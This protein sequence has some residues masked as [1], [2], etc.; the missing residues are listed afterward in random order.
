MGHAL[1]LLAGN[2]PELQRK[3]FE[4]MRTLFSPELLDRNGV[5]TLASNE[6]RFVPYS[7][8][9][10]SVWPWDNKVIADELRLVGAHGLAHDLEAR[11]V[12]MV[13]TIGHFTE[14]V[15]GNNGETASE[16]TIHHVVDVWDGDPKHGNRKHYSPFYRIAKPAQELQAWTVEAVYAIENGRSVPTQAKDPALRTFERNVLRNVRSPAVAGPALA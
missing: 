10:G 15:P 13:D 12:R 16:L 14:F 7:Y 1:H 2:D 6:V 5:R 8:H 11:I 4:L 3:R 9:C